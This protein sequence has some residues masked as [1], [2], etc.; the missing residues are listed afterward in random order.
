MRPPSAHYELLFMT[1]VDK[2]SGKRFRGVRC[3]LWTGAVSADGYG[4][5]GDHNAHRWA[6]SRWVGHLQ[7]GKQVDHLCR[8]RSCVQPL[9]LEQVT[10]KEN[11]LRGESVSAVNARKEFCKYGHP[12]SGDNLRTDAGRRICRTC[13]NATKREIERRRRTGRREDTP[14]GT[15]NGYSNYGC[16]CGECRVAA[17]EYDVARKQRIRRTL[18]ATRPDRRV[19]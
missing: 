7:A 5:F 18:E 3:W 9:H 11:T 8:V 12:L 4:R 6:Y 1:K 13:K 10:G 15:R 16:R 17:H 19:P 14:H 2:R